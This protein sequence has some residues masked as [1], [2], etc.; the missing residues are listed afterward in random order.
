MSEARGLA[1]V[2]E[3]AYTMVLCGDVDSMRAFYADV[4]GLEVER[5]VAGRYLEL[6]AG[7]TRLAFRLRSRPYDGPPRQ[8]PGA[9]VQLAFRVEPSDVD[10]AVEQLAR[11][12][13]EPLEPVRDL[14]DFGH[15]VLFIADPEGNVVE[16]FAEI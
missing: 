13:I 11:L 8:A 10:A 5:E 15:R 14:P 6:R 4:L 16:I 3:L 1:A 12:G 2:D 7:T 9:S